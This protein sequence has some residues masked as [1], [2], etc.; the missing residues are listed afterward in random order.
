[1]RRFYTEVP[2][3]KHN[4]NDEG[5]ESNC[6]VTVHRIQSIQRS[7]AVVEWI[8]NL[9]ELLLNSHFPTEFVGFRNTK[10]EL[11]FTKKSIIFWDMTPFS[12]LSINRRIGGTYRLHLQGRKHKLSKKPARQQETMPPGF[13]LVSC[14][15]HFFDPEE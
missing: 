11:N 1:M 5:T 15:V 13:S 8:R 12:P 10:Y 2:S 9:S 3:F 14:S 6:Y 7:L 4:Y